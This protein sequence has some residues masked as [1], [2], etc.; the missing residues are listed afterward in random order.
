MLLTLTF[1]M[2]RETTKDIVS[3]LS[4]CAYVSAV[5]PRRS[6]SPSEENCLRERRRW[7]V[8]AV[9]CEYAAFALSSAFLI[10][11]NEG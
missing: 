5:F 9:G 2:N 7:Y 11:G 3:S 6:A 1:L 8:V 4:R 10:S